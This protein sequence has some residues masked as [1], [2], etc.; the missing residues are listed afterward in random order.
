[1]SNP[2]H[3]HNPRGPLPQTA[4]EYLESLRDGREIWLYGERVGDV[5][6]HPAFRNSARSMARLYRA[7][8]ESET[9]GRMLRP[10]D[11]G[12]GGM[13]HPFFRVARSRADLRDA[14]DAMQCWQDLVFGWMGR[15]PDYKAALL[16]TLGQMP[17][18][19]GEYEANARHWYQHAQEH[20][21]FF[22]HAIANPPVD[23]GQAVE[24]SRDV[25]V[26]VE[27]ETDNGLI[28]SGAK[29]VATGSPIAQ[30]VLVGHTKAEVKDKA[31]GLMFITPVA[32]PGVR[33]L[34]RASYEEVA[35]RMSTPF[36]YP[37]SSRF[38]E[39]DAILIFDEAL[40]PWENVL[41]YDEERISAFI[42][43]SRWTGR[44]ILQANVRLSTK[45]G[46]LAGL[47]RQAIG[48]VGSTEERHA[49]VVL[50]ELLMNAQLLNGLRAGMIEQAIPG[51]GG[52]L[53]PNPTYASVSAAIGPRLQT[54]S[55]E[56][57][58]RIIAS[59]LIYLNSAAT[60]FGVP[61]LRP[62]LDRY[63]R[64][65]NG[66]TAEDRSRIM[67]L[68][69][70][71]TGSEFGGRHDLYEQNYLAQ[72][73][74]HFM[75]LNRT[76]GVDGTYAR[77]EGLVETAMADYNLGGWTAPDLVGAS[78]VSDILGRRT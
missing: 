39:N 71:A 38:D 25:F 20:V 63:L 73:D 23:R 77:L 27:R 18:W 22:A 14:V 12:S 10:T 42:R 29:V 17:E 8:H 13:T 33:L 31:F 67:K 65:S 44:G 4:E 21:D 62:T 76:A 54:R 55:R 60:D 58:E 51:P 24:A 16:T 15:T 45:L 41:I 36:D 46:F 37:L 3:A 9:A 35:A 43:D 70:D 56:L 50:G 64:G 74:T 30:Y 66:R 69:W 52:S 5:T 11:T 59:G 53:E 68:L 34:A 78:D 61:Q 7:F 19:F 26:H 72:E 1:M 6:T 47:V 48:V 49:Q 28:V 2:S 40:V 32:A 57:A 75:T